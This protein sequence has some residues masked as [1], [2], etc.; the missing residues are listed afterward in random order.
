MHRRHRS[1]PRL[2]PATRVQGLAHRDR[3]RSGRSGGAWLVRTN[4]ASHT[5]AQP[6]G[7]P[8]VGSAPLLGEAP[9]KRPVHLQ[10]WSFPV[11]VLGLDVHDSTTWRPVRK[12]RRIT[13]IAASEGRL[14]ARVPIAGPEIGCTVELTEVTAQDGTADRDQH[15][16]RN[17]LDQAGHPPIGAQ[18][19][20]GLTW[21]QPG[22]Y[23]DAY[24]LTAPAAQRGPPPAEVQPIAIITE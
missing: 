21:D 2:Q 8:P 23:R 22:G 3:R 5:S 24:G 10:R 12:V 16:G 15:R 7:V 20:G 4:I 18:H 1:A 14:S 17:R 6:G 19:L 9:P 11:V 13:F